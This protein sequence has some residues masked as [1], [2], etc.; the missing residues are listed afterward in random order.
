LPAKLSPERL[1]TDSSAAAL[2]EK[3]KESLDKTAETFKHRER[4]IKE[5]E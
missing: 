4:L 5:E 3:A 1:H 2:E